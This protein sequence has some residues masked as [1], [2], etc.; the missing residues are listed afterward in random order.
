MEVKDNKSGCSGEFP[1][2]MH[3]YPYKR[4]SSEENEQLSHHYPFCMGKA[5]NCK[6]FSYTS[7]S[8][9]GKMLNCANF[10]PYL[11][12]DTAVC[13]RYLAALK[14]KVE[15]LRFQLGLLSPNSIPT[16]I[17]PYTMCMYKK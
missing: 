14:L 10:L 8:T 9:V 12:L 4:G 7:K 3:K 11:Y 5:A 6:I 1:N 15:H 16:D 2:S 17:L 13:L